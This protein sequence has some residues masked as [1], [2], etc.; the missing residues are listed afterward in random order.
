MENHGIIGIELCAP[1][2]ETVQLEAREVRLPGAAGVLTVL[3]GHT[4]LMTVLVAGVVV[5]AGGEEEAADLYFSVDGGFAEIKQDRIMLLAECFEPGRE[6]DLGRAEDAR[7]RAEARLRKRG[8]DLDV[9][10][11]ELAIA[12]ALARIDARQGA[13]L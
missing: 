7:D 10:R 2:R 6:I 8:E 4:P 1:V 3:P 5:V 12:R 13:A 9:E 11:A